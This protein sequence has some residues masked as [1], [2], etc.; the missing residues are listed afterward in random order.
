MRYLPETSRI[1]T[2]PGPWFIPAIVGGVLLV[3]GAWAVTGKRRRR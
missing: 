1:R 3:V 2:G